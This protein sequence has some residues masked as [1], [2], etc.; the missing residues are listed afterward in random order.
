MTRDEWILKHI[1]TVKM[2]VAWFLRS[3]TWPGLEDDLEAE[4]LFCLT[5]QAEKLHEL[6]LLDDPTKNYSYVR[7]LA[8]YSCIDYLR[9]YQNMKK[10]ITPVKFSELLELCVD[11]SVFNGYETEYKDR[12]SCIPMSED[13]GEKE[14]A[15]LEAFVNRESKTTAW[16]RSGLKRQALNA[17]RTLGIH[18]D[19]RI[20]TYTPRAKRSGDIPDA[21]E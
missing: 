5:K 14:L 11:F 2:A 17:L 8:R 10:R 16:R 9:R 7:A 4:A 19:G 3:V 6:G 18:I 13:M 12:G 15:A 21:S 20:T 1:P